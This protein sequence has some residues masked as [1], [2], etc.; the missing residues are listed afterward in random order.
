MADFCD[1]IEN[2]VVDAAVGA[3]TLAATAS[4]ALHLHTADPGEAGTANE[5]TGGSY[6]A[7]T[8]TF[9]APEA[10]TGNNRKVQNDI[11]AQFTGMPA[12][13]VTHYTVKAG[14]T[15]IWFKGTFSSTITVG[16][17]G[18]IDIAVGDIDIELSGDWVATTM[19]AI[20]NAFRGT[21]TMDF[22]AGVKVTIATADPGTGVI[23]NEVAGI[24][25]QTPTWGAASDGAKSN[26]ADITFPTVASATAAWAALVR[27]SDGQVLWRDDIVDATDTDFRIKAGDLD[28]TVD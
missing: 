9:G 25:R 27:D 5:V 3:A 15:T 23:A 6:A 20:L 16:A 1:G 4:L 2:S 17:G 13:S 21:A 19:D 22:T 26:T 18:D 10:G 11:T 14:G 12:A 24:T 7:Q 28:V 8:I